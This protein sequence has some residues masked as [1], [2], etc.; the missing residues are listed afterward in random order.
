MPYNDASK[1]VMLNAL[2]A[3]ITHLSLHTSASSP[4]STGAAEAT[5]GSPAYARKV[6]SFG[7]PALGVLPL[8]APVVFD[9]PAGTYANV[10]MWAGSTFLGY[11]ALPANRVATAQDTV[12]V[13][14]FAPHLNN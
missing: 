3:A 5:G 14:N 13:T 7:T 4:G 12:T 1:A 10:G 2:A 8:S 9:V 11:G 6:P